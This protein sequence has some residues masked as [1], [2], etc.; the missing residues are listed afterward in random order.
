MSV[1]GD[2]GGL[3]KGEGVAVGSSKLCA[4]L[5]GGVRWEVGGSDLG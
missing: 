5:R 3:D 4:L 2:E 1:L